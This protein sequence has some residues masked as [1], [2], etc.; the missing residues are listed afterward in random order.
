MKKKK[1]RNTLTGF[2]Q[3][4]KKFTLRICSEVQFELPV[5]LLGK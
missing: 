4:N 2:E 3:K 5:A 1:D